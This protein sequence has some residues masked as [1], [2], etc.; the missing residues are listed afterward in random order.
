M[1][2]SL[3]SSIINYKVVYKSAFS[4]NFVES[5]SNWENDEMFFTNRHYWQ[6]RLIRSQYRGVFFS[7]SCL[8][9][10][11]RTFQHTKKFFIYGKVDC[12]SNNHTQQEN[13][14]LK[15]S[16]MTTIPSLKYDQVMSKTYKVGSWIIKV[17]IMMKT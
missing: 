6:N 14:D 13:D 17:L 5:E 3:Y 15:K 1:V 10:R 8:S 16:L 7:S 11:A 9:Y 12:W 2:N 4:G